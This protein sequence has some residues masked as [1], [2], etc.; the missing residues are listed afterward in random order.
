MQVGRYS[1]LT[2]CR[3]VCVS[4]HDPE[5]LYACLSNA[6]RSDDGTLYRSDDLGETWRRFDHGVKANGTMM[7]VAVDR[8]DPQAGLL[9]HAHRAGIRHRG[10]RCVVA[11]I[12]T[13]G[14]RDRPRTRACVYL[15][16]EPARRVSGRGEF[17]SVC[18]IAAALTALY[19]IPA[20]A[21]SRYPVK[22]IR[23]VVTFPPGASNDVIARTLGEKNARGL[24]TADRHR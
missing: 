5:T 17:Y 21:Q 4:P 16:G 23:L 22:P 11:R 20:S 12:P 2:Y 13:A 19:A 24:G 8:A 7:C 18:S 10:R 9:R 14:Q 6:A 15:S 3:D 1:P